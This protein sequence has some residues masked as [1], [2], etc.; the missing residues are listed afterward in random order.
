MYSTFSFHLPTRIETGIGL[1][2]SSGKLIRDAAVGN[3]ALLVTDPGVRNAGLAD[4]VFYSLRKEGFSCQ[5][6]DRV[7]PNPKDR[8]CEAG[9]EAAREMRADVIVAVGGGS[10]LDSAKAIA[11]I[12][13]HGG[14][15][16]DYEGRGKVTQSVTPVVAVPTTA[17]TGSEVTRSAVITDTGRMFK[18]TVKDVKLAPFLA[19]VDPETTYNLPAGITASTGMDAL[20]HAIEA[21]T[22][23]LAN[24]MSDTV[25]LGAMRRIYPSLREVVKNGRNEGARFEMMLGSVLAGM[26]FSHSDVAAVHCMAEALGGLYDTPH[27]VANSMF[28]PIVTA[29]NAEHDPVRHAGVAAACGLP[30]SGLSSVEAASLLVEELKKMAADIGIPTFRSLSYIR[31]S[32]FECLAEA[33][34][35]NGST[36]SNCREITR[37]DYLRLFRESY[38][39][40]LS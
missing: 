16:R 31:E 2:K 39:N 37:E 32:D 35:R 13:T 34:F 26:A 29:F 36:P 23:R 21:Y 33:S 6:F 20:V 12:Q 17:G 4:T 19:I 9:G 28:L 5:W 8:D 38:K 3:R 30:V 10:V 22:C 18:M 40:G 1:L 25:A 15:L 24:P 14:S 7:E 11:L 27:G